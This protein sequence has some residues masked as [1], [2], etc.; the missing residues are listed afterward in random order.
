V[1]WLGWDDSD[2]TWQVE[3]DLIHCQE[4]VKKFE[5]ARKGLKKRVGQ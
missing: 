1:K 3:E 2:N 5:K 4:L